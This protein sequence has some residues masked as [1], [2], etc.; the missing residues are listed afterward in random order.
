MKNVIKVKSTCLFFSFYNNETDRQTD[1]QRERERERETEKKLTERA[2]S[3][4]R[5]VR[6]GSWYL[7]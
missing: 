5:D 2:R 3:E 1:R 6:N 7:R 4:N